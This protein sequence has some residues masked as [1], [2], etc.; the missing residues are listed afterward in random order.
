M[1]QRIRGYFKNFANLFKHRFNSN[2]DGIRNWKLL[3]EN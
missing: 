2:D 3:K 1:K